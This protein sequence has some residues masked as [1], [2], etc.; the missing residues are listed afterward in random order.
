MTLMI[1]MQAFAA[2]D[3]EEIRKVASVGY[4]RIVEFV[5]AASDASPDELARFLADDSQHRILA[6]LH[7]TS[8]PN[9]PAWARLLQEGRH[10]NARH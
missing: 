1:Q 10:T 5:Q 3:D 7:M 8:G 2:C 9:R 6:A 4:G